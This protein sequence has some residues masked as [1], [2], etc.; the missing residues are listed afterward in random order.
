[1]NWFGMVRRAALDKEWWRRMTYHFSHVIRNTLGVGAPRA[2]NHDKQPKLVPMMFGNMS[3][4][5]SFGQRNVTLSFVL[6]A[7]GHGYHCQAQVEFDRYVANRLGYQN[8]EDL[9]GLDSLEASM[10]GATCYILRDPGSGVGRGIGPVELLPQEATPS[11]IIDTF[12]RMIEADN[13]DNDSEPLEPKTP[14]PSVSTPS[15]VLV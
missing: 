10:T 15:P 7:K 1:M 13:D 11:N 12:K 9:R 14:N 4:K 5:P 2:I 6:S 3:Y 8:S